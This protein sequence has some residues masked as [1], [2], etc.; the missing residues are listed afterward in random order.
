MF[1]LTGIAGLLGAMVSG[2]ARIIIRVRNVAGAPLSSS[3]A[4]R[5]RFAC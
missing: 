2:L 4:S 1:L 3:T 5:D